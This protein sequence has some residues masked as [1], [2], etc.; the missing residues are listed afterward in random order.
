MSKTSLPRSF[1]TFLLIAVFAAIV[2][3]AS[4]V[5]SERP[6]IIFLLTDDQR[7]N[8]FGAMGHPFAK[9]PNFDALL[10]ESVRF[11]NSY[12]AE[13]VCSPSRVSYFTG[14]H[15]RAHGV[16]FTSSWQLTEDQWSHSYP[17]LLRRA[18]YYT[19]FVGK[20]GLEYYTFKGNADK[21]FDYWWGHDG[22]TKFLPKNYKSNSTR[23]YHRA[24]K[25]FITSIMG[26]AMSEFL[27]TL[28]DG[29]PF[30]LSVSLNI[31]HGS[32]TTSMHE[33]YDDWRSMT[34]AA[35]E[36]EQLKGHKFYDT[37]YRD[38]GID[39]PEDTG[40]D[41]H[42]F[43]PRSIMDQDKGRA[44]LYNYS[45]TKEKSSEHHI[46][47]YQTISGLDN[48]LGE[49][50]V[51]LEAR[52]LRENTIIIFSSDHGLLMGEY[53][54]GGK[55]LLFD[56]SS[57]VP[58]FVHDPRL[59]KKKRGVIRDELV[60]SLDIPA[61]IL[62]YAG[63]RQPAFSYGKSLRQLVEG[64]KVDWRKELFLE[65]LYTG[66]DTPFQEG[67]RT[68]RWK[69][70]RC[71]DAPG[72]VL[73][74]SP[75]GSYTDKD[76]DFTGRKPDIEMLFDLQADPGE[77]RNLANSPKHAQTL[78]GLRKKTING[79]TQLQKLA[80]EYRERVEMSPR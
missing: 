49:L 73:H 14:V 50:L 66:R 25:D 45:Y 47:Y 32:Q 13:P 44:E 23:P 3:G 57:K 72:D 38:L 78:A 26:E 61:T 10:A 36:N 40:T 67:M 9:T 41:P 55:A 12:V 79:S 33:G 37:L 60:S 16:G 43:M 5:P 6:N 17:A 15:E 34:R 54:M 48:E 4:A 42:R 29:R 35:N 69:Y 22:W 21:K 65:S 76:I 52:G 39:L 63:V 62:D 68:N 64:K 74:W 30:C 58:C 7:D 24:K 75:K 2:P 1:S 20:F 51:Q 8:T 71:F 18:G 53:G 70:I 31:P 59:P 11:R 46:R 77:R 80:K 27:S 28:P 56:L 19:G